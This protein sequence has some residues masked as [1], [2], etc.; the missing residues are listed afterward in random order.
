[1]GTALSLERDLEAHLLTHL[2]QLE[3]NLRLYKSLDVSGHQ[4]E[5][6]VVGRLD[7][8]AVDQND[9][10]VVIELKAGKV[11]DRVC[12]QIL[13][14]I[15]WARAYLANGRNVRGIIVAHEFSDG[16]KYAVKALPMITLKQYDIRFDFTDID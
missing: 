11:D 5:T 1:F 8:L 7:F 13:R 16:L 15:G 9:D 14:Y 4:L 10:L 12:G 2:G 6:G 3:P